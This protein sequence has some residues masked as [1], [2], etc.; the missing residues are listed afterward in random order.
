MRPA[1]LFLA[2]ACAALSLAPTARAD[3]DGAMVMPA[4]P[5]P[6][7][8]PASKAPPAPPVVD[9]P[10]KRR[11][12]IVI[13]LDLGVGLAGSSGYP[14]NSNYI[15]NPDYYAASGLMTGSGGT[16]FVMGALSDYL[17][18]GFWAGMAKFGNGDWYSSGGGGGLRLELFPL[19]SLGGIL[20][21][22]GLF[23]KTGIGSTT[24]VYKEEAGVS[25]SGVGSFLAAGAFYEF[26]LAKALGGH[27]AMGPSLE[28]DAVFSESMERHGAMLD[29]RFLWYGGR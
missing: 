16:L 17:N 8:K 14:N 28:Y 15:G 25:Q 19:Y 21:D 3:D 24:L 5:S 12:G 1:L 26:L 7:A 29:L 11:G 6:D 27:F 20:R 2:V 13:G 4:E 10:A 22:L 18:F 23:T 9:A